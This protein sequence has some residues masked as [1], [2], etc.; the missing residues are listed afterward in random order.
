V[1][2]E[3]TTQISPSYLF[4]RQALHPA[5]SSL[6]AENRIIEIRTVTRTPGVQT[7]FVTLT[8]PSIFVILVGFEPTL[9][10]D[11][12]WVVTRCF[13]QLNYKTNLVVLEGLE[14]SLAVYVSRFEAECFIQLNYRTN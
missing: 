4:S 6:F 14:P 2:L 10:I 3:P 11:V 13:I 9:C 8:V 5:R 1:G 12:S 7:Q